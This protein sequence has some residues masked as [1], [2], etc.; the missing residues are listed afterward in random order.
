MTPPFRLDSLAGATDASSAIS[1]LLAPYGPAASLHVVDH[2]LQRITRVAGSDR[3]GDLPVAGDLR[4]AVLACEIVTVDGSTWYPISERN[5]S[6]LLV[7]TPA[8]EAPGAP[9]DGPAT[10]L[11]MG[12]QRRRFEDLD[13]PR[14]RADMSVAAELQWELLP[15][16]AD[17]LGAYEIASTLEPAYDVAGDVYD[18]ALC[19][20]IVWAYALD[21]MGHGLG[22]TITSVLALT[23]IRNARRQGASLVEQMTAADRLIFD[24]YGA[25][26]FVTGVAVRL[27]ADG[28]T[29]FVN[30]GHE[31]V[32][33]VVDGRVAR[34]PLE[35]QMPLG[36]AGSERYAAQDG[37]T[38]APGDTLVLL[39]DGPAGARS[40]DGVSWGGVH[41]DA[42]IERHIGDVLLAAV[43]DVMD[44]V[45]S[46]I[47]DGDVTD[48]M[49]MVCVRRTRTETSSRV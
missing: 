42:A 43:H 21:G 5:Q 45:M 39:S 25:E 18:H 38:L 13:R 24:R 22:A 32:R 15:V 23:A 30:A 48:D 6:V 9:P 8:D 41:L 4:R 47:G 2:A 31:P 10:G 7:C 29:Q 14:R 17:T 49:T 33:T 3:V 12:D 20:D 36:V 11:V 40:P 19:G 37:P 46:Y 34:L 28:G 27:D 16:R 1:E 44:E 35:A 26:R